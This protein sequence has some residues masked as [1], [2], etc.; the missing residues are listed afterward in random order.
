MLHQDFVWETAYNYTEQ[1]EMLRCDF[2]P[3]NGADNI[4]DID[5]CFE[6][7]LIEKPHNK[8][9]EKLTGMQNNIR[10]REAVFSHFD[11]L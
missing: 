11:H 3:R 9:L 5:G 6:L 4:S 7:L 10:S 8:L 1:R 2:G